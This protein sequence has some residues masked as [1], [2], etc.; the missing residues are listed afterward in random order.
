MKWQEKTKEQ[1]NIIML[2][3][4]AIALTVLLFLKWR[5][6]GNKLIALGRYLP[7]VKA[8]HLNQIQALYDNASVL[9]N[10]TLLLRQCSLASSPGLWNV[11][12]YTIF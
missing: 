11:W 3:G 6:L 10:G 12:L 2:V 7:L 9:T 5:Y 8:N 1:K 4:L